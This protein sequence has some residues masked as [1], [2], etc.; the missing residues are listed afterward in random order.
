MRPRVLVPRAEGTATELLRLLDAAGF[1]GHP[2]PVIGIN[3]PEDTAAFDAAVARLSAGDYVWVGFASV[4]AVRGV[5]DRATALGL[6][7]AVPPA[8]K[9]AAVGSATAAALRSAG[10]RVDLQPDRS[11]GGAEL[12]QAWPFPT[13]PGQR[14]LLPSAAA[15]LPALADGLTAKGYA[16]ERVAAYRTAELN[17][18]PEVVVDVAAGRYAAVLLTSS[19][20]AAAIGRQTVPGPGTIIGCIGGTTAAAARTAGLSPTYVSS[21]ATLAELV[22]GLVSAVSQTAGPSAR[23]VEGTSS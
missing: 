3:P 6:A 5:V 23:T 14:V 17:L 11:A 12:A 8:T 16:V 2:V 15:G 7:P 4:N 19:S 18:P 20:M 13:G 9:I 10:L 1:D 21:E 22:R